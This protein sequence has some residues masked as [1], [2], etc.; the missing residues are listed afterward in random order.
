VPPQGF[1]SD[2]DRLTGPVAPPGMTELLAGVS[3][4]VNEVA[5]A[6]ISAGERIVRELLGRMPR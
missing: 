6:G 3:E 4:A 5:K 1:E 2:G